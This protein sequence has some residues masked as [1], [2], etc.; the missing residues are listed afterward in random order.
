MGTSSF[1]NVFLLLSSPLPIFLS[2]TI[3][4][5]PLPNFLS[6]TDMFMA[7][8]EKTVGITVVILVETISHAD[9]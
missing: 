9:S 5:F 2:V 6:V 7:T 1:D 3:V 8:C 4:S